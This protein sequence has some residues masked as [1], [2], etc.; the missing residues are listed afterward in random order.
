MKRGEKSGADASRSKVQ[1]R[2]ATV[3]AYKLADEDLE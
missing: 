1:T 3:I 2:S